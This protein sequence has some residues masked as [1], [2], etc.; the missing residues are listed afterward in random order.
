MKIAI[1]VDELAPGSAPKLIGQPLRNLKKMGHTCEAVVLVDNGS[2]QRFP[3]VYDY[4]LKDVKIRYLFNEA[5]AWLKRIDFKFPGFSFFSLHHILSLFVAPILIK[6][7]EYDI[8]VA[9]CQYSAFACW[10]LKILRKIPYLLLVWDPSTYTL[11]KIYTKTRLRFIYPLLYIFAFIL[12]KVSTIGARA[13]ITSGSL[14]HERFK[15]ITFKNLEDLYPGCFPSS[16]FVPYS[17]RE[18]AI[19]T[20]DRWDIGNKPSVFLELLKNIDPGI[21]LKIGGFWHPNS[22]KEDFLLEVGKQNLQERVELL[23]PLNEDKIKELC[24]KVILHLHPNEEA[25]GMQTLEAAS[26][27]CCVIIPR[28]S[29]VTDLF[30]HSVHG[31]FPYKN[32]FSELVKYVKIIFSDIAKSEVMG[33]GAWEIAKKYTWERYALRLE[34]ILRRYVSE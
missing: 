25:F 7:E 4:H 2:R 27:G 14:H 18:R 22:L 5:P 8:I 10:G 34:Q 29:G 21:K 23:G 32:D 28:G 12:D 9:H 3:D 13:L 30:T 6:K 26:C 1:L 20:F 11:K 16:V 24:S 31:F 19:L 17:Q 15:K 33:R